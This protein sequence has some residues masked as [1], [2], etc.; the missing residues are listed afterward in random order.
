MACCVADCANALT[1]GTMNES[2]SYFSHMSA[3]L[4][5]RSGILTRC[6][7]AL[8]GSSRTIWDPQMTRSA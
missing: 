8:D 4:D 3:T 6:L 2:D 7:N 5:G 1:S